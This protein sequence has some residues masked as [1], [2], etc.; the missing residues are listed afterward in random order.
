MNRTLIIAMLLLPGLASSSG[1]WEDIK[2]GASDVGEAVGDAVSSGAEV[3]TDLATP[4]NSRQEIDTMASNTLNR[5]FAEN[6]DAKALFEQSY[7]YAVFDTRKMSFILTAGY[8]AGVGVNRE[9]GAS[10]Y[11]R[12]ATGGAA[13][14]AGG[15]LYQV[16]FLFETQEKFDGFINDGWDGGT[17]G[18]AVFGKDGKNLGATFNNG[19][20][21]YQLTEKGIMLAADLTGTKYW[22]DDDLN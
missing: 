22:R 3:V 5:L 7:G 21:F 4:A 13:L 11:M 20:A 18:S 8:G 15:Q 19:L 16:V 12:M 9:T 17:S 6:A 1:M 2:K 14:G 10:T